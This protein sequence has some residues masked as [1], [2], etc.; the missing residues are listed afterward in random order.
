[1]LAEEIVAAW[2]QKGTTGFMWKVDFAK[3]YDS[4]DW[5][6]LERP[7][8]SGVSGDVGAVDETMCYDLHIRRPVEQSAAR[9]M[10]S[11]PTRH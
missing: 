4:L 7:S 6:S 5:R 11:P 3:A 9:G 2:R 8:T 1:M 10:D